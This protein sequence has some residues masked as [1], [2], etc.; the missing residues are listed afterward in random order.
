MSGALAALAMGLPGAAWAGE[1][2]VEKPILEMEAAFNKGDAAAAKATHVAMPA[3]VD[4]V[5]APFVWTGTGAFDRW[6]AALG[7]AEA[8]EGK[9]GGVVKLGAPIRETV[10][11]AS[12]YVVTPSTYSFRQR[13]RT[14]RET[15]TITFV[16]AKLGPAWKIQAW[17]WTS[18]EAAVVK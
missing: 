14:M 12:A 8:A 10:Q 15:G 17:T 16:L 3:I 5:V 7:K 2:A 11:G 13:G 4:E 1:A 18:P 9:T 6:L